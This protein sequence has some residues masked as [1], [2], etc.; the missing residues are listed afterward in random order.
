[1]HYTCI[2]WPDI[3]HACLG[4]GNSGVRCS[5]SDGKTKGK[6]FGNV[7]TGNGRNY[8]LQKI[9]CKVQTS[10]LSRFPVGKIH[11]AFHITP[12]TPL[13]RKV[14]WKMTPV[15]PKFSKFDTL[16]MNLHGS[17]LGLKKKNPPLFCIFV[18][19]YGYKFWASGTPGIYMYM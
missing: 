10:Q 12:K 8:E 19:T 17:A 18:H 6:L 4:R 9:N 15:F 1:M 11:C 13:A 3:V 5:C 16:K 14:G 7:V 2:R